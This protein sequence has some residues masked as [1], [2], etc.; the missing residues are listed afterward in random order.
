MI[1]TPNDII[2]YVTGRH[3]SEL[4]R[5]PLQTKLLVGQ[6]AELLVTSNSLTLFVV[7]FLKLA[8]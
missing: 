1:A 4:L 8:V 5:G 7:Q 3:A 6:L 2:I